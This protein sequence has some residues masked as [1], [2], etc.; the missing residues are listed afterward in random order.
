MKRIALLGSTGSIGRQ[1]LNVIQQLSSELQIISLAAKENIDLL[2]RQALMFHPEL[3]AVYDTDKAKELQKRLPHV[4]VVAGREGL[5][6]AASLQNIDLVVS[7]LSGAIGLFPTLAAIHQGKTIALANKEVLVAGGSYVTELAKSKGALLLPA[8]SEHSALFQLLRKEEREAVRRVILTASG[9][10]FLHT[11]HD[12]LA[13][14]DITSALAHPTWK[15]G[16]KITIDCSTL[17]NKGLEVIE[18]HFL[19]DIPI[20]QI[21]VVIHPQSVIHSFVEMIDGSVLA[22]LSEPNME[23]PIQYALTYPHRRP[24]V[25]PAF[26]FLRNPRLDF[27]T[28]DPEKFPCLILAYEALKQGGSMPCFM[29][30]ANEILVLRFLKHEIRWREIA[31]KLELLMQR[32]RPVRDLDLEIIMAIDAAAREEASLC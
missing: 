22:Q 10:P 11:P 29:N 27:F 32:H 17:M 28:P 20:E 2:E 24:S 3:I 14:V 8:D 4:S 21:E 31:D 12:A 18:A 30:A 26:D 6:E 19:F 16:A 25:R 1:T 23:L 5:E 9:G 13:D 15:M 7:A